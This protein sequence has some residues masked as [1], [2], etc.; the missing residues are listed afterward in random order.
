MRHYASMLA[1]RH[2]PAAKVR[3]RRDR[4]FKVRTA[5]QHKAK[6]AQAALNPSQSVFAGDLCS[7]AAGIPTG[8]FW[9]ERQQV[10]SAWSGEKHEVSI[11]KASVL[12]AEEPAVKPQ[13]AL[14]VFDHQMRVEDS[15]TA[16]HGLLL[17]IGLARAGERRFP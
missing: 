1:P 4:G 13:R 16:N 12:H 14:Y 6:V 2:E 9:V 7:A 17:E 10:L 5:F 3:S 8:S 15:F 11:L